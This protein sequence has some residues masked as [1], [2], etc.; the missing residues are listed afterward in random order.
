MPAA[1][2]APDPELVKAEQRAWKAYLS[3]CDSRESP[4]DRQA[5]FE[6]WKRTD[7]VLARAMGLP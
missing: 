5:A 4:A 3:A 7:S 2:L 6:R 1:A